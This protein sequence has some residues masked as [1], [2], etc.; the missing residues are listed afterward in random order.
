MIDIGDKNV[1]PSLEEIGGFVRNPLFSDLCGKMEERYRAVCKIEFSQCSWAYGWNVKFKKAGKGLCTVYPKENAI[2]VLVVVG[3]KE[4]DEVELRL[5]TLS[6]AMQ[7][8]YRNTEEG[9][10]QR[11]LMIDLEEEGALYE[12]VLQLI[13]IRRKSK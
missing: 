12:D 7:E 8:I 13:D 11:W 1:S 9:N 4:K 3:K 10:G 5:P 2:T 6:P